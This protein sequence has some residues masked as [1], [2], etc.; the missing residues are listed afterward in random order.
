M[1]VSQAP[2]PSALSPLK[3]K[4]FFA[5]WIAAM[6][7]NIGSLVQSVGEKW[8]MTQLT[9]SALLVALIETGTML[10]VLLLGLAAGAIADIVD[11]RKW[12][13][14]TQV[15]MMAVAATLAALTFLKMITPGTLILMAILIGIGSSLSMPAFQAI[16]PEL[17]PKEDLSAGVS[18]N[19][20]GYNVSRAIG[21]AL[22][23]GIV[24]LVGAGWAFLLNA[25]SFLAVVVVLWKWKRPMPA[26]SSLPSERFLGA[27]KV[28]FRYVRHS[29][30]FQII[31]LKTVGYIWFSG[32]IFSLL[33]AL[34]IHELQLGS[35]GFGLLMS[36]IGTGA[37][38]TTFVLPTLRAR[39]SADQLITGFTVLAVLA[40]GAIA[41]HPP[42]L[43]VA[44]CLFFAG[45]SWL[46]IFSTLNT[47]IQI[48]VPSWVKARAFG[49][50]QM[51][52]GGAVA[53][54]AAFWGGVAERWG[55]AA[56]FALSALGM[57]VTLFFV[58]RV[59]ITAF[60]EN[61]DLSPHEE[62]PHSETR[63]PLDAGPV[64]VQMEFRIAEGDRDAFL[65]AMQA[66]RRL[67]LRD[68]AMRWG[69]FEEPDASSSGHCRFL[70]C[71]LSSSMGEHLRQHHRNTHAD[72]ETLARAFRLNADGKPQ[73]RHL[74]AADEET[75]SLIQRFWPWN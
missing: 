75:P 16:V 44:L 23:G 71:Y 72:R 9:P 68:G 60:D 18:L 20:A 41:F 67:R 31:L 49:A 51:A 1:D 2:R 38:C 50:Y 66:V 59:R 19:S 3:S 62:A 47:A 52:W 54:A 10:P 13:I 37:V 28:G 74:T 40:Q 26:Q 27:M 65:D 5:I 56:G 14:R 32:V 30:H 33:P 57:F 15:F 73:A 53:L 63:I 48:S 36:C 42:A 35:S 8:Q 24:S 55:L 61:Q 17:L 29:H 70:E 6:A 7:S 45:S 69:L 12:L 21:P 43:V 25:A 46:A 4:I 22:G 58:A 64:M 34:A 11:R 39:Y